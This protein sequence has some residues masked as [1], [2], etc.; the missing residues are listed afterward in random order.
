MQSANQPHG[1]DL[2]EKIINFSYNY[3]TSDLLISSCHS[4]ENVLKNIDLQSVC[5]GIHLGACKQAKSLET[6]ATKLDIL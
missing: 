3:H 1:W 2:S 4:F 6:E 5:H